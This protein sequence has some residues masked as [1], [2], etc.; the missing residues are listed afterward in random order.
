M[1]RNKIRTADVLAIFIAVLSITV[2][3]GS[4]FSAE[5]YRDND[6]VRSAFRGNDI[7]TAALGVPI[8]ILGQW[9]ARR[10]SLKGMF[11]RLGALDYMMY[12]YAFYLFGA[13][14]NR[15]FL[16]YAALFG[17]SLFALIYAFLDLSPRM[18]EI[19][20]P[21]KKARWTVAG[22]MGFVGFGLSAIY[23]ALTLGFVFGGKLPDI[24][25]KTGHPTSIVFALDLTLLVPPLFLGM[26]WLVKDV[27]MGM[28]LAGMSVVKG[29]LY[30]LVLAA[31]SYQAMQNGIEGAGGEIPLWLGLSAAGGLACLLFFSKAKNKDADGRL[32]ES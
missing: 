14:F 4:I 8:L 23:L 15:Y 12:N 17:L 29:P 5:L 11:V 20:I 24:V 10:G 26:W 28:A 19:E 1:K 22:Y 3:I 32:Q 31:G 9:F 25:V 6:F 16:L 2:S 18:G 30:T 21:G 27:P 7:V 13:A